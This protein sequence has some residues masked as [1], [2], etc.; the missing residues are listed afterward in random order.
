MG[1]THEASRVAFS[2]LINSTIKYVNKDREKSLMK[3]VDLSERFM[4]DNY[5][6]ESYEGARSL[7]QDPDGKWTVSIASQG[8]VTTVTGTL[9]VNYSSF[10]NLLIFRLTLFYRCLN[11]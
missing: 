4:G 2:A 8:V 1:L 6:K 7:I 9:K 10:F 5:P 11:C 3:L